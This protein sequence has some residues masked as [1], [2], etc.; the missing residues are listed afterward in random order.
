MFIWLLFQSW[1]HFTGHR[2]AIYSWSTPLNSFKI[3]VASDPLEF[4]GSID[5]LKNQ[6]SISENKPNV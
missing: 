1:R 4:V 5:T 2:Q 6:I 3:L